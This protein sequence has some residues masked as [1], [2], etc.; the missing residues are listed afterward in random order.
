[1]GLII[2]LWPLDQ[3]TGI[4]SILASA[5]IIL[6]SYLTL[7][8]QGNGIDASQIRFIPVTR[9]VRLFI[10]F[11]TAILGIPFIALLYI[12]FAPLAYYVAG[13][14]LA[15]R[16]SIIEA[17][18][19]IIGREEPWPRL[20]QPIDPV[21]AAI[22]KLIGRILKLILVLLILRLIGP[23]FFDFPV[24]V[25]NGELLLA[26]HII[27]I[28]EAAFVLGFGYA[29]ISS[30][31]GLL[32]LIAVRLVS[33]IGATK[34]TLRRILVDFLYAVLGL[35]AWCYSTSFASIPVIGGL[36]SKIMMAAAAI[37]FLITMYRLGRRTHRTFAEVYE[38]FIENLARRLAHE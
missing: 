16:H 24:L 36:V 37:L 29:I 38:K 11:L 22:S 1:M 27:L 32:D 8:L 12:A 9:D 25:I 15:A 13:L 2:A 28:S 3:I 10:V 17:R 35:V 6:V 31:K 18:P 20:L 14:I 21:K 19:I 4:A 26:E 34:E 33:R 5:N 23:I 7:L 30:I